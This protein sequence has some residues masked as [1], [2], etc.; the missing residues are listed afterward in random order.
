MDV[1]CKSRLL[2]KSLAIANGMACAL[3]IRLCSAMMSCGPIEAP[4]PN[5]E[6]EAL[7]AVLH[8]YWGL[9][10]AGTAGAII[11]CIMLAPLLPLLEQRG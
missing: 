3:R 1:C 10:F 11:T 9:G 8:M 4:E 5:R 7:K 2:Q 6:A